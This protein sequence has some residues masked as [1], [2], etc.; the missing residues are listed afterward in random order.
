MNE[1]NAKKKETQTDPLYLLVT[2][3]FHVQFVL[4]AHM[5]VTVSNKIYKQN[6]CD[7]IRLVNNKNRVNWI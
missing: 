3:K 4:P 6:N 7:I 5:A 1:Q 2:F